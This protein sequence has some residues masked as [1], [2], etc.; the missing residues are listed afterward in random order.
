M[1]L[2]WSFWISVSRCPYGDSFHSIL[3]SL[4]PSCLAT[5]FATSTSKP[6]IVPSGFFSPRPGWS[7][8]VPMT[9]VSPPPPPPPPPPLPPPQA[10]AANGSAA[11]RATAPMT[12]LDRN[13][14][15]MGNVF[16]SPV[17]EWAS[18]WS[19]MVQN[20]AEEVL[21]AV[22]LRMV[23]ELHWFGVLE[24]RAVGHEHHAVGGTP[25]EP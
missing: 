8:L 17:I 9:I 7:N 14:G 5:Y 1:N 24:D 10:V 2:I 6:L 16:L 25:S 4:N 12:R 15:D 3:S 19:S 21:G 23:E 18:M 13:F 11:A 20:L 22:G